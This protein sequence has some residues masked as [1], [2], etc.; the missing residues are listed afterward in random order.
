MH[1]LIYNTLYSQV[2]Q[3]QKSIKNQIIYTDIDFGINLTSTEIKKSKT[4]HK[5]KINPFQTIDIKGF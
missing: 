1:V 5:I 2:L 3:K 4:E